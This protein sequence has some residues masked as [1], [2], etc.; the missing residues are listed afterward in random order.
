MRDLAKALKTMNKDAEN[1]KSPYTD[2]ETA[3]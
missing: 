3:P 2:G 1:G